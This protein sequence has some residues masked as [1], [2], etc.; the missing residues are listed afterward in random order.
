MARRKAKLGIVPRLLK[1]AV[2][3]GVI[4]ACATSAALGLGCTSR[5]P[6]VVAAMG[7]EYGQGPSMTPPVVA[8]YAPYDAEPMD[9]GV[10]TPVDAGDAGPPDAGALDAGAAPVPTAIRTMEPPVV[11]AYPRGPGPNGGR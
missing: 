8:A 4:P 11:A 10:S 2:T 1:N 5:P 7:W 3:V 6:P 9:A